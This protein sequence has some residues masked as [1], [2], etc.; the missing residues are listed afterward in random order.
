MQLG[1]LSRAIQAYRAGQLGDAAVYKA[2]ALSAPAFP[3]VERLLKQMP[4]PFP[5]IELA[6]LRSFGISTF[7]HAYARF[8]DVNSL[9]PLTVSAS[10][11]AA[12]APNNALAVRYAILH[13]AFHVLLGFD[14]SLP[15]ELGVWSFVAEQR[16]SP[17]YQRAAA[18]ARNLY[19]LVAP[20]HISALRAARLRGIALAHEVPCLIAQPIEN[21][22]S[23]PLSVVRERLRIRCGV[24]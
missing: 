15:G 13:D 11:E 7:G 22:W 10:V 16:Y 3:H 18:F 8:M 17:T 23:E 24:A 5:R 14:T 9:K 19:P 1:L 6:A 2:A 20:S 21:Y 4:R 12:L